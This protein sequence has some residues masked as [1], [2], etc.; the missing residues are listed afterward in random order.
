M[1]GDFELGI[2]AV[3]PGWYAVA[4][5]HVMPFR[6]RSGGA[7]RSGL[8]C[9]EIAAGQALV[10]TMVALPPSGVV[11]ITAFAKPR[12]GRCADV[13]MTLVTETFGAP[14][15]PGLELRS[16]QG[17]S[18]EESQSADQSGDGWCRHVGVLTVDRPLDRV[19]LSIEARDNTLLDEVSVRSSVLTPADG[20]FPALE[21]RTVSASVLAITRLAQDESRRARSAPAPPPRLPNASASSPDSQGNRR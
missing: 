17:S 5:G 2:G 16:A 3:A 10:A 12:S 4:D 15:A 8:L 1:N 21:R 19:S 13:R 6:Y 20:G 14:H 9:A 11:R 18:D 7:C